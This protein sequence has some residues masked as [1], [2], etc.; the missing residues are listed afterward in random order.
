MVDKR[1]DM[2][3]RTRI[4]RIQHKYERFARIVFWLLALQFVNLFIFGLLG[5][6]FINENR[7]RSDESINNSMAIQNQRE[8]AIFRNCQDQN[9]RNKTTIGVLDARL[10]LLKE[11][12]K[13]DE[14]QIKN[15][16]ASRSFTVLLIDA[17]APSRNCKELVK[18]Q[19]GRGEVNDNANNQENNGT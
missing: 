18:Q 17:L 11:Q 3:T 16:E 10:N 13:L 14:T 8:D 2:D 5:G 1:K 15:L 6:W 9:L 7:H 12:K 19:T 4:A